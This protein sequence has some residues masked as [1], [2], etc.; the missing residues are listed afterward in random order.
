MK[1]ADLNPEELD[2]LMGAIREGR[3]QE[4]NAPADARGQAIPYDLTSRDRV[5]RGRMPAL[6]SIHE[7]IAAR[8]STGL[9]GRTRLPLRVAPTPGTLVPLADLEMLL[10]PPAT[11]CVI[12][13][14][15]GTEAIAILDPGLAESLVAA[16][17]G[18]KAPS[19]AAT[20]RQEL[21]PVGKQVLR[22]LLGLLTD[23]M[24]HA[25]APYLP[26]QPEVARLEADPRLAISIAPGGDVAVLTSFAISGPIGGRI[27]LAIPYTA[28][29]PAKKVL[30]NEVRSQATRDPRTR[31]ALALEVEATVVEVCAVL[32]RTSLTLAR[33][34]ELGEG[35]VLLLGTEES[36]ALP[37]FVEGREKLSGHPMVVHGGMAVKLE[38]AFRPAP[39]PEAT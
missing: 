1:G 3:V 18:D 35:D 29:Q 7:Q 24:G 38:R 21:T 28:I 37:L 20:D 8:L 23:A 34:L 31:E 11:V 33:L 5:L 9:S 30:G 39:R 27:Q 36:S 17:L 2:A 12:S 4:S 6:D 22:K 15:R 19:E 16:A 10:A 25:W 26:M 13:L 32:G 14:G